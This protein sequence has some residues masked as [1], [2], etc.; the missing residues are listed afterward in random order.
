MLR[1]N[2]YANRQKIRLQSNIEVTHRKTSSKRKSKWFSLLLQVGIILV[3]LGAK[4]A[5]NFALYSRSLNFSQRYLM[6]EVP[7][8]VHSYL[9]NRFSSRGSGWSPFAV[10]SRCAQM[11]VWLYSYNCSCKTFAW[12]HILPVRLQYHVPSTNIHNSHLPLFLG[13]IMFLSFIKALRIAMWLM[14]YIIIVSR[15][16]VALTIGITTAAIIAQIIDGRVDSCCL[17]ALT[18]ENV[19]FF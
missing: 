19:V 5:G 9:L 17:K 16:H 14:D 4:I 11:N 8:I 13:I 3:S 12:H 15:F 1:G 10:L 18:A 7:S 2:R 6:R